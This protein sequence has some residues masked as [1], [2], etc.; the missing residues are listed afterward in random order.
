MTMCHRVLAVYEDKVYDLVFYGIGA[1]YD[2][3]SELA[4]ALYVIVIAS[5]QFII[6]EPDWLLPAGSELPFADANMMWYMNEPLGVFG[7]G[8]TWWQYSFGTQSLVGSRFAIGDI[9]DILLRLPISV[10]LHLWAS[11]N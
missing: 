4:E 6:I 8:V 3:A 5:F 1:N 2:A 11:L 7:W 10:F 9:G